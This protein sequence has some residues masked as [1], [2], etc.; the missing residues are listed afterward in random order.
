MRVTLCALLLALVLGGCGTSDDREQARNAVI[1]FYH[2]IEED[3]GRDA[4]AELSAA[5]VSHLESQS[6]QPCARA[7]AELELQ[8][9]AVSRTQV[10]VTNAKV[11]VGSGES[12]FLSREASGWRL[13]AVGCKPTRGKSR[14]RPL[15]CEA[16]A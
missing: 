14:D 4:C 7:V 9:G 15:E 8:G 12:A 10:F 16:E 5:T 13:S 6:G 2:A 11:D 3:R 1:R